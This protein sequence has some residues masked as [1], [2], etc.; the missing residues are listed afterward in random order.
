[1]YFC[2]NP[3]AQNIINTIVLYWFSYKI[4]I[5]INDVFQKTSKNHN[6]SKL[7]RITV[8]FKTGLGIL[9]CFENWTTSLILDWLE[10]YLFST[11]DANQKHQ[12]S[13]LN[14]YLF[15]HILLWLFANKFVNKIFQERDRQKKH[16]FNVWMAQVT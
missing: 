3:F 8:V 7:N 4:S 16:V 6:H 12:N 1:M 2:Q 5:R 13:C 15:L 11:D 10:I 9:L 14:L